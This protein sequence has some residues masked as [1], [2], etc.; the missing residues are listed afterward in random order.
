MIEVYNLVKKYNEKEILHDIS[1]TIKSGEVVSYLGPNGAGK[2]TT[3]YIVSTLVKPT[4]GSI[5][6]NGYNLEIDSK[7]IRKIIG[8]VF[9]DFGL[10]PG[11]TVNKNLNF[12]GSLYAITKEE[13]KRR[14]SNLL[15]FFE[16]N[17][18]KSTIIAKLSKGTKQK[19]SLAKSLL[20]DP[21][22]LFLDEP[23]SGLDPV[24]SKNILDLIK[25]M[26]KS[27][28]TILM[29]THLL[30]KAEVISDKIIILNKGKIIFDGLAS[31]ISHKKSTK[32]LE[33]LFFDLIG[34]N[35]VNNSI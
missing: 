19:V 13:R 11:L 30:E 3:L 5:F 34:S 1:F 18:Y 9:D 4:S 25:S 10:Y 28:K 29:T 8:C 6:L 31:D 7:D 35:H 21:E 33:E 16:L 22:I 17:E 32:S 27:G 12:I 14:I 24:A 15:N 2:T 20:H 26:K 23:T